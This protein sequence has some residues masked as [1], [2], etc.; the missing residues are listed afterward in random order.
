MKKIKQQHNTLFFMYVCKSRVH[1]LGDMQ[2]PS[3]TSEEKLEA[4]TVKHIYVHNH[5]ITNKKLY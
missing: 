5:S 3:V 4:F 2:K 1:L